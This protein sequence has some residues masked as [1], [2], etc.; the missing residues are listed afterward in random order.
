MNKNDI[1]AINKR[2]LELTQKYDSN[3]VQMMQLQQEQVRLAQ[4]DQSLR[5][6]ISELK[7]ILKGQDPKEKESEEEQATEAQPQT[8]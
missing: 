8:P 7:R 2:I 5:G 3:R 1:N 6:G 4:M